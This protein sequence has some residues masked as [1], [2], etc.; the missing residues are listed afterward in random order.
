MSSILITGSS[1]LIGTALHTRLQQSHTVT[2]ADI[3]NPDNPVDITDPQ[4]IRSALETAQPSTIIHLAAFT[5]VTAAWE[6]SG[7][8]GGS[9]YQINVIGTRTVAQAARDFGAHLIHMSTAYVFDGE[10]ESPYTEGDVMNPIEWYG[11]TKARA[12][13]EIRAT[14]GLKSTI[15]RI[16]KPFSVARPHRPD[17]LGKILSGIDQNTLP[18]QFTDHFSGPTVIE[19]L[20]KAIA[21][22]ISAQLTGTYHATNNESWSDYEFAQAV[23]SAF[24]VPYTVQPGSLATYLQQQARPYQKNTALSSQK[25]FDQLSFVPHTISEALA[26]AAQNRA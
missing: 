20:S 21:D 22:I 12:E 5:N 25:L 4:S 8:Q 2:R 1:G 9:C 13:E 23:V 15:L 24:N 18:P 7:D 19:F 10:K 16:D 3:S 11:E 17:F 26:E 14:D 6:Q